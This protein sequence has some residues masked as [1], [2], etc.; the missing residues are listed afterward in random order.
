MRRLLAFLTCLGALVALVTAACG[1]EMVVEKTVIQTVVVEKIVAGEKVRVVETVVV[2]KPV[3]VIETVVVAPTPTEQELAMQAKQ[4]GT[5]RIASVGS[6]QSFGPLWT[7]ASGT[8]N[9]SSTI[10]EGLLAYNE[11]WSVGKLLL[12]NWESSSDGLTWT[13]TIRDGVEFHDGT[14][15]ATKEVVGTLNRQKLCAPV[16]KQ[17]WEQFGQGIDEKAEDNDDPRIRY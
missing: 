3:T 10:L 12:D 2:E 13:F 7:T 17:V 5:L 14:P 4:A 11:D 15:L 9:V 8:G 16:F 6:V 1:G